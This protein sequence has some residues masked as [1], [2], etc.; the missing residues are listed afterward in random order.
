MNT[1]T[2]PLPS[3]RL[4]SG[5]ARRREMIFDVLIWFGI[6]MGISALVLIPLGKLFPGVQ[7][8]LEVL[9]TFARDCVQFMAVLVASIVVARREG[10]S[11]AVYGLPGRDAF[12]FKFWEGIVWGFVMLSTLIGML[13]AL[14]ALRIDSIALAGVYVW[15]YAFAWGVAFIVLGLW[16]EFFFRGFLLFRIATRMGYWSAAFLMAISFAFAHLGNHG[17]NVLGIVQVFVFALFASF[18]LE[19][20]GSLWFPIGYHAAWDWAQTYFWGTPDSGLVSVGHYFTTIPSGPAWLS[21]GTG[22]PEG[23][24]L[25]IVVLA[26]S[27]LI[28][29]WR[30][31]RPQFPLAGTLEAVRDG[32]GRPSPSHASALAMRPAGNDSSPAIRFSIVVRGESH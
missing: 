32:V 30:F 29:H 18:A 17:E 13:V 4:S 3:P 27:A 12:K 15:K 23:S 2:T 16:E 31:P 19:R 26:L 9:P 6:S 28:V 21:G 1:P 14:K 24:V 10:V 25:C 8:A 20:T 5:L 11:L 22:G 7:G